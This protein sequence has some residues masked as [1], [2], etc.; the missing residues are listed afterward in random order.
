[1]SVLRRN[2]TEELATKRVFGEITLLITNYLDSLAHLTAFSP[3]TG[4][5]YIIAVLVQGLIV[6]SYKIQVY[7]ASIVCLDESAT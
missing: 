2:E 6:F 4:L 1:M 7:C 3:V 5:S